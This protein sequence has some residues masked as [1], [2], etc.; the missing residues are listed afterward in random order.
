MTSVKSTVFFCN[1]RYLKTEKY[2]VIL[3]LYTLFYNTYCRDSNK[4]DAHK[5]KSVTYTVK[6]AL[7][8]PFIK[9]KYFKVP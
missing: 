8:G 7:N 1:Q 6:P 5:F 4:R 3:L 9:P 2:D